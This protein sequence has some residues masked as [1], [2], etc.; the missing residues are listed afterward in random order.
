MSD[1]APVSKSTAVEWLCPLDR[2]S[3]R[4]DDEKGCG[5]WSPEDEW[6]ETE[7][8]CEDCGSHSAY[9]CPRCGWMFDTVYFSPEDREVKR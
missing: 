8:A 6:V 2:S 7:V 1:E 4:Y 3:A 5:E 9:E